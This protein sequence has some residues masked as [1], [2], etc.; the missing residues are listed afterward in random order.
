MT[1][2]ATGT[3]AGNG[4]PGHSQNS[5]VKSWQTGVNILLKH[6]LCRLVHVSSWRDR[7]LGGKTLDVIELLPDLK[8]EKFS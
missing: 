8:W 7:Q 2:K 1:A 6:G 4:M 5:E 3:V